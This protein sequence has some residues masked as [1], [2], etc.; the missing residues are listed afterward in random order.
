MSCGPATCGTCLGWR[1]EGSPIAARTIRTSL[2]PSPEIRS[3]ASQAILPSWSCRIWDAKTKARLV[4]AQVQCS[5]E[6]EGGRQQG[7]DHVHFH[8]SF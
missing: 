1:A 2:L 5:R 8:P 6:E 7:T 3:P 4:H